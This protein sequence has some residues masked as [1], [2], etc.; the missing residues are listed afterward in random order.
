MLRKALGETSNQRYILTI[1]GKGYRFAP[2]V[3]SVPANGH[4]WRVPSTSAIPSDDLPIVV[5]KETP[6]KRIRTPAVL[7]FG[8]VAFVATGFSVWLLPALSRPA[9]AFPPIHSIAVLP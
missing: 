4:V 7:A 1:Q 8:L 6:A 5:G 9:N 2:E 3:K